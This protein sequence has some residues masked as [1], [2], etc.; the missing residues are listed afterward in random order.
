MTSKGKALASK[1]SRQN[2]KCEKTELLMILRCYQI[3]PGDYNMIV[4][5]IIENK[6]QLSTGTAEFYSTA[7]KNKLKSRVRDQI[8][9]MLARKKNIQDDEISMEVKAVC[10]MY[11][12]IS[13]ETL[14]S[15]GEK[16]QKETAKTPDNQVQS[17]VR[18]EKSQSSDFDLNIEDKDEPEISS[19]PKPSTSRG[20]TKSAS[21][22]TKEKEIQDDDE[23]EM[24]PRTSR[25][26]IKH[27]SRERKE[28]EMEREN[29]KIYN[30][31]LKAIL[32]KA[33][34]LFGSSP[35]DTD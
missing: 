20:T 6:S 14:N 22:K 10:E 30:K 7:P 35:S 32:P 18:G 12:L 15:T 13:N 9:L 26:T 1:G 11:Q 28:K 24:Q 29:I 4:D 27:A 31:L 17:D 33:H 3:H 19:I 34:K 5:E 25:G 21:R 23:T 16:K 8:F 2:V